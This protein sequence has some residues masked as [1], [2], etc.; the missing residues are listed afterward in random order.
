[1]TQLNPAYRQIAIGESTPNAVTVGIEADGSGGAKAAVWWEAK[2]D[3]DADEAEYS[4]VPQALAAAEAART[5]HGFGE[6][7]VTLQDG[8]V[9]RSEWGQLLTAPRGREPI[10]NVSQTDLSSAETYELAAG[11]EAERDA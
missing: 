8:L 6:V 9:W 11:I 5:L 10:G 2:G 1:M 3:I 7:V 4:D